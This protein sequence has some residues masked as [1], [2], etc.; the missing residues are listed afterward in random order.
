MGSALVSEL[1]KAGASVH[2]LTT[3]RE[4][5]REEPHYQGFYWD[6]GR[7]E[8]DTACFQGVTQIVNLAG[9]TIAQRW[10]AANRRKIQQS[11][12]DS[13]HT[14]K[15]GLA[16]LPDHEITYLL[17]ASAIGIYPSSL[18][19]FYTEDSPAVDTGFLGET[20][21]KWEEAARS[22][23]D[24]GISLGI[25]R[26]GL[27]LAGQG[28][29]LPQLARPIRLGVGAPLGDGQQWQSWIHLRDLVRI[30]RLCLEERLEGVYNAVAPNPVTNQK[31]TREA[32]QVLGRPLWLPRVPAWALRMVLGKMS[33]IL[34]ASQ[35]VSSEKIQQEGFEFE[36]K[37]VQCALEDLLA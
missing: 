26:I 32:A 14:L 34:L 35:R 6:P 27:V 31:L 23:S 2:Y 37:N 29:A 19:E 25:L 21:M 18:T 17:S 20:V 13:L 33:T 10:T 5:I 9:A 36:F 4:K 7:N 28:G 22:F 3:S 30:M 15:K 11:R 16:S 24:L 8:I 12:T 1:R